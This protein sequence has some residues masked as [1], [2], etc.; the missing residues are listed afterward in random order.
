MAFKADVDDIRDSLSFRLSKILRF[1]GAQVFCSD[2]FA[3]N[4]EFV[5]KEEI[6]KNCET[7]I[8]AAPHSSYKDLK[9]SDSTDVIDIWKSNK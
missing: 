7:V 5:T 4:P 9:F 6:I 3:H 2:E 1:S 8:I